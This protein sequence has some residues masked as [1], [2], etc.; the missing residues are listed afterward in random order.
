MSTNVTQPDQA[1]GERKDE[2]TGD[3]PAGG[4]GRSSQAPAEG[5][6]DTP[7]G[8]AGSPK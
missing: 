8:D 2:R 5:A 7:Q 1:E 3:A 6:D 4:Q